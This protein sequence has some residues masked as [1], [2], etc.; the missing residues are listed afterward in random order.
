MV[1]TSA[2]AI[3]WATLALSACAAPFAPSA[4]AIASVGVNAITPATVRALVVEV[5]GPGIDPAILVNIPVVDDSIATGV[6][7]V[8]AGSGRRIVISAVDTTGL[9][10]HR[11]DTTL[12]LVPGP[13]PPLA[14]TLHPLPATLGITVTFAGGGGAVINGG[15]GQR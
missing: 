7:E 14:L 1:T 12:T 4:R 5:D 2:R 9:V 8:T 11:G 15:V 3:L 6:I 10:T 13:N